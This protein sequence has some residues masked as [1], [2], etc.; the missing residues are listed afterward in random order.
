MICLTKNHS[1]LVQLHEDLINGAFAKLYRERRHMFRRVTGGAENTIPCDVLHP[2]VAVGDTD[3]SIDYEIELS[4]LDD[5]R[6]INLYPTPDH[7]FDFEVERD[8]FLLQ[9]KLA[10]VFEDDRDEQNWP[11]DLL[12]GLLCGFEPKG[13]ALHIKVYEV[14][15]DGISPDVLEAVVEYATELLLNDALEDFTIPV[16]FF[17]D[18]P[19][20][21][22]LT[23][24]QVEIHSHGVWL[25]GDLSL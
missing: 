13:Q 22:D 4:P 1:I 15:I 17:K 2:S 10:F 25:Y 7:V 16:N 19:V 21:A 14:D 18:P 8:R 20:N 6:F 5:G 9:F 3:R 11:F 23:P 12:V 24:R